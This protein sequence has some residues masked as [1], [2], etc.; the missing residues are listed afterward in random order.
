[1]QGVLDLVGQGAGH[2]APGG[3]LLEP[4]QLASLLGEPADHG[5]EGAHQHARL[6]AGPLVH[7]G[8]QVA[9]GDALRGGGH[10]LQGPRDPPRQ[11][12]GHAQRRQDQHGVD[13]QEGQDV[14]AQ[15]GV[16]IEL[17]GGQQDQRVGDALHAIDQSGRQLA[18]D[19][20]RPSARGPLLEREMVPDHARL[21]VQL[22][23]GGVE[24]RHVGRRL[25][26]VALLVQDHLSA[27]LA[28]LDH[29]QVRAPD[30]VGRLGELGLA[31]REVFARPG[32][33]RPQAVDQRLLVGRVEAA[34]QEAVHHQGHGHRRQ[35]GRHQDRDHQP[36]ADAFH[37]DSSPMMK[38][39]EA[40]SWSRSSPEP[41]R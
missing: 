33:S 8:L 2:T 30:A 3:D 29:R 16:A 22:G 37:G 15:D 27:H 4:A 38:A 25:E 10:R 14:A 31:A 23:Q 20:H 6:A 1:M 12:G 36:R 5:V 24:L 17:E 21:F 26:P 18:G 28:G 13:Q 19:D 7:P 32:Q 35:Q 9:L 41:S 34:L 40:S 11:Q 39:V